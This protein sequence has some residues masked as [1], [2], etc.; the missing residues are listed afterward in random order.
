M[1]QSTFVTSNTDISKYPLIPKNKI[2]THFPF[3]FNSFNLKLLLSGTRKFPLKFGMNFNFEIPYFFHYRTEFFSFRNNPKSLD[4]SY[5][6]N[7]DHWDCLGR[8]KTQIIAKLHGTD[9]V[10]L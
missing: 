4:L 6:A 5:K 10:Y 8:I 1:V 9:L 7:L 3:D 2:W